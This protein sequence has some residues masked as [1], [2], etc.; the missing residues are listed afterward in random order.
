MHRVGRR[1][2]ER[3]DDQALPQLLG[4][5][6]HRGRDHAR[7]ALE[8]VVQHRER[9]PI[10]RPEA[11]RASCA[12]TS[13]R[14]RRRSARRPARSRA[15]TSGRAR[16]ARRA[17][18]PAR[19]R[20]ASGRA[21]A[22]ERG[23]RSRSAGIGTEALRAC[24]QREEAIA[25]PERMQAAAHRLGR[26][27][28][29]AHVLAGRLA[30]EEPAHDVGAHLLDRVVEPD[31]V[32]PRLVHRAPGL[33]VQLLVAEHGAIRRLARERDGHEELRVEPEPDL[34]AHLRDPVGREPAL[35]VGLVR[36]IRLREP[37]PRACGEALGQRT[38]RGRSRAS[39][40]G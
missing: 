8:R 23:P 13:S 21:A 28:A 10:A 4:E 12:R 9:G 38:R 20:A 19:V 2:A 24:V 3:I 16:P 22:S 18:A 29:E 14:G 25:V 6:R 31:R 34:L 39:R 36:Q 11:R 1:V 26:A 32:A 30:G 15:S 37:L 17:R 5:K 27:V 40:T 33:V 35:P 7:D